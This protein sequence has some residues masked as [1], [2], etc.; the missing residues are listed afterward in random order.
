MQR[1][2]VRVCGLILFAL[3][4]AVAQQSRAAEG[5]A[6]NA[7]PLPPAAK[8]DIDFA[9]HVKPL[10]AKHCLKCHGSDKQQAG[11][12]LDKAAEALRGGD[13]GPAF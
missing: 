3:M 10:F 11:L 4:A 2:V 12:R 6:A 5:D 13:S 8:V 9:T 1:P 7:K